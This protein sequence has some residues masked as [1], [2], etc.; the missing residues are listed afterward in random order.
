VVDLA[1]IDQIVAVAAAEIDAVEIVAVE[2]EAGKRQ[3]LAL[4]AGLLDPVVATPGTVAA[5][6]DL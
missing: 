3:G 5:V 6:G 2:R 4:C 1:G